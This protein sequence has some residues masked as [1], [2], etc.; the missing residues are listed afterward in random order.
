MS[1]TV[2]AFPDR[3]RHRQFFGG[4]LTL[5]LEALNMRP[6]TAAEMIGVSQARL[7]H[8]LTGRHYPDHYKIAY[9]CEV[10]GT[11]L[12]FLYLG[13][14]GGLP[15]HLAVKILPMIRPADASQD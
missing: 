5:V 9:F 2:P 12:D 4:R 10:T 6:S 1:S 15:Q 7:T 3:D 13:R 11:S 8:W 14:L